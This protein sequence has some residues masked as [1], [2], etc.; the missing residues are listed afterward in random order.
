MIRIFI[1]T[2]LWFRAFCVLTQMMCYRNTGKSCLMSCN[3][4]K[5]SGNNSIYTSPGLV[6]VEIF[7]DKFC[8]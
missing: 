5:N 8:L 6:T 2:I 7:V 4:Y 3:Y 1:I